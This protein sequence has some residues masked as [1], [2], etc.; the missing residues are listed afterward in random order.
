MVKGLLINAGDAVVD[1]AKNVV[2]KIPEAAKGLF[3]IN[4]PSKLFEGYG[5]Y[6]DMGLALGIENSAELPVDAMEDMS[7]ELV[8]SYDPAKAVPA[9]AGGGSQE[10]G[11]DIVIPVYIGQERIDEMVVTATDRANYMSG[12]RV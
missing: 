6:I 5:E 9:Y 10:G 2:G 3:Q 12:G 1:T 4:S 8:A 7:G 11:G